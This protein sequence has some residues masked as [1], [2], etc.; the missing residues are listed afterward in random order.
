MLNLL[1]QLRT[2]MRS[3]LLKCLDD[4]LKG[5]TRIDANTNLYG[6]TVRCSVAVTP[7]YISPPMIYERPITG[8]HNRKGFPFKKPWIYGGEVRWSMMIMY[9]NKSLM[10]YFIVLYIIFSR[11]F[12]IKYVYIYRN[13]SQYGEMFRNHSGTSI[14]FYINLVYI[15]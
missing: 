9:S 13:Y 5:A 2:R 3:N 15:K 11:P 4:D 14:D 1:H 6:R 12:Q 10:L 8:S 7:I